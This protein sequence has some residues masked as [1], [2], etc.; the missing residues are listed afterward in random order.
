MGG[1]GETV[2]GSNLSTFGH[3]QQVLISGPR[4]TALTP[5]RGDCGMGRWRQIHWKTE[6]PTDNIEET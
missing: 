3:L 6:R 5:T 1:G 2:E 4:H